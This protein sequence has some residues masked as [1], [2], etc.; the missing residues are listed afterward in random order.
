[1]AALVVKK[2]KYMHAIK[3]KVDDVLADLTG[4]VVFVEGKRVNTPAPMSVGDVRNP[5]RHPQ[6]QR[7]YVAGW[8]ACFEAMALEAPAIHIHDDNANIVLGYN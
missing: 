6:L 3:A 8:N 1:V 7:G 2:E 5:M 4:V